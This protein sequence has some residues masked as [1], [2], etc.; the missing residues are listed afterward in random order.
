MAGRLEGK[1]AVITGAAYGIGRATA[2]LFAQ[3]G[4]AVVV[5]DRDVEAGGATADEIIEAG[6]R[7]LY[8]YTDVAQD[9]DIQRAIH[10]A[11]LRWGGLDILVNNAAIGVGAAVHETPPELWQRVLDV[12]LAGVY[13][14][15][16]DGVRALLRRGGGTIVNVASVQGMFGFH[17]WAAYAASKGGVIALTRQM[18]VE[19]ADRNIRVNAVCP[20]PIET[21][22]LAHGE[23]ERVA[24]GLPP[25]QTE[26]AQ[27][28][29][30][31]PP[32]G[33]SGRPEE[34]AQCILFLAS[35][36]ASFVTGH[37]LVVDGGLTAQGD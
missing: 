31:V 17:G 16:R 10:E 14:G 9:G 25:L 12:N 36:E 22:I 21:A 30:R 29:E 23:A 34:V 15:C 27:R 4:A 32:M 7:A 11:E 3:E 28:R 19:Y 8:V 26:A 37:C 5:A 20:G 18:A 35:D 6:G 2:V 1:V 13:R 33:R 24:L